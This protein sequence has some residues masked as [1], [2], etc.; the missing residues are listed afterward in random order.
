MQVRFDV[1]KH[2]EGR[3]HSTGFLTDSLLRGPNLMEN[4]FIKYMNEGRIRSL[5]DLKRYYRRIVMR[6]HP[7]AVGSDRLVERYIEY[8]NQYSEARLAIEREANHPHAAMNQDPADYRLLFYKEF[9]QLER[10]ERPYAPGTYRNSGE[11]REAARQRLQ[12]YLAKWKEDR[13]D[14]HR[15]A[16]ITYDQIRKERPRG[17]YRKHALLFNLRPVF[18][19]ILSYQLTGLVFYRRQLSQNFAGVMYQLERRGFDRLIEYIHFL[20]ADMDSGPAI[21]DDA[22]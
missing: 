11:D 17:P 13:I 19:N 18:H 22:G 20:I 6:T 3:S 7:D 5:D 2:K 10:M 14:L 15:Q 16:H 1:S 12:E 21:M 9:Y 4:I 8:G